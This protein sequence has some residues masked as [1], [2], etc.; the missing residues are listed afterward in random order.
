MVLAREEASEAEVIRK[1][2]LFLTDHREGGAIEAFTLLRNRAAEGQTQ[3]GPFQALVTF[4]TT[5]QFS[6]A[7]QKIAANGVHNGLHGSMAELISRF[8]AET[9]EILP[10]A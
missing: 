10:C 6:A 8:H 4:R 9:F 1:I 7:F 2:S 3:V 5:A